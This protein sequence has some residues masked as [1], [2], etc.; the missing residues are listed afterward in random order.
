MYVCV[1]FTF[2]LDDRLVDVPA[3]VKLEEGHTAF[4]IRF[5]S[6]V[7]ALIFLV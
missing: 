5:S 6:V 2:I 7:L 4:L 1:V 3:G